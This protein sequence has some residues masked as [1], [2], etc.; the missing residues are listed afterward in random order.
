MRGF[1]HMRPNAT[2]DDCVITFPAAGYITNL[3]FQ[4][5]W[6]DTSG[7]VLDDEDGIIY[8]SPDKPD[9]ADIDGSNNS[10]D[11]TK[12][13]SVMISAKPY[14]IVI[15]FDMI[16]G[17]PTFGS[18][19]DADALDLQVFTDFYPQEYKVSKTRPWYLSVYHGSTNNSPEGII[20]Q[21]DYIPFKGSH[22]KQTM[23]FQDLG[24][25]DSFTKYHVLTTS[26]SNVKME[27]EWAATGNTQN[28]QVAGEGIIMLLNPDD[29]QLDILQNYAGNQ[30]QLLNDHRLVSR[31]LWS[32]DGVHRDVVMQKYVRSG[33]IITPDAIVDAGTLDELQLLITIEGIVAEQQKPQLRQLTTNY[34]VHLESQL[35]AGGLGS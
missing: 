8:F 31:T 27:V 3:H 32:G 30:E 34:A 2:A 14:G 26:L 5:Y 35:P 17:N 12:D 1:I 6:D 16:I 19:T 21:F 28:T 22:F 9:P 24:V 18:Y 29:Y 13:V 20:I 10:E 25:D 15:P 4:I 33:T 23:R 11:P 7:A